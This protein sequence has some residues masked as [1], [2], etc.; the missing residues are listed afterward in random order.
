MLEYNIT[1]IELCYEQNNK[2]LKHDKMNIS[3][4]LKLVKII[5]RLYF[6]KAIYHH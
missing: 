5:S 1:R 3:M 6:L 4:M 2:K